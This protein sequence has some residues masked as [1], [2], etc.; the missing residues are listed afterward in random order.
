MSAATFLECA[1][2]CR[3]LRPG[4]P[5]RRPRADGG[6]PGVTLVPVSVE[7]VRLGRVAH[8]RFGRGSGHPARL[9]F[10]DCFAY[11]LARDTGE[12]L[13]YTGDDFSHTDVRSV[14]LV[15]GR[16]GLDPRLTGSCQG[17]VTDSTAARTAP[18]WTASTT[19]S[20]WG[21]R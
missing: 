13:L 20:I 10:G 4:G 1:P 6:A 12:P 2:R 18:V 5:E 7:H 15:V 9:N 21:L 3:W 19:A 14:F 17:P 16:G 8:Q 11:A